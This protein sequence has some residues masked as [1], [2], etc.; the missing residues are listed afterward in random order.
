MSDN[1]TSSQTTSSI[2]CGGGCFSF[3]L[4]PPA[5]AMVVGAFLLLLFGI[6]TNPQEI[7]KRPNQNA[8]S[9]RSTILSPIFTQ[10][11]LYWEA[12]I[13][14]WADEWKLDA[15]LVATVMQI[16][17]CGDPMAVSG[18]GAIGLFQVMPYHFDK[19]E[20]AYRPNTN[21][22]RGLTYLLLALGKFDNDV[23]L[24]LAGYNGGIT[25]ASRAKNLWSDEMNR[26]VYWGGNIFLD[27]S[28]S[29]LSSTT[30]NEW[31]VSGGASLCKKAT[32]NIRLVD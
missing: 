25:G 6:T 24:A 26:Y 5:I 12:S 16:E 31:L 9:I 30:L 2:A 15:N 22:A 7:P 1:Y 3:S 14:H 28:Q 27:A 8:A 13:I 21:A 29:K 10:E 20:N 4:F 11:V 17:S 32:E 19:G 23:D 18:S